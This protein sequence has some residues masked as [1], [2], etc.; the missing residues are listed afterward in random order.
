MLKTIHEVEKVSIKKIIFI[1]PSSTVV[2][3]NYS[4]CLHLWTNKAHPQTL[5]II[6]GAFKDYVEQIG[7]ENYSS[8]ELKWIFMYNFDP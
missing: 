4:S 7:L 3:T 2:F 5:I 1:P 8:V 6:L